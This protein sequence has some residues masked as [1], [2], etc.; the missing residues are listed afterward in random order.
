MYRIFGYELQSSSLWSRA[1]HIVRGD[2]L[3][4]NG[5]IYVCTAA[6]VPI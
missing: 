6:A 4:H 5:K 1:G 3:K 2:R